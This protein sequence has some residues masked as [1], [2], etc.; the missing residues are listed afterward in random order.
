MAGLY[1]TVKYNTDIEAKC[2]QIEGKEEISIKPKIQVLHC[3]LQI[4]PI[5]GYCIPRIQHSKS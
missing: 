2:H 1:T 3:Y 4:L 5:I